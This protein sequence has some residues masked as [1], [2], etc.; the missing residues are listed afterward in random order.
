MRVL[1]LFSGTGSVGK[2]CNEVGF[3]CISLDKDMKADW[4]TDILEWD[5]TVYPPGHFDFIWASPPCDTFSQLAYSWIGRTLKDGTVV[6]RESIIKKQEELGVPLVKRTLEILDYFQ[7][8]FYCIENPSQSRIKDYISFPSFIVDYC[9]YVDWGYKKRTRLFTNL[10]T[11]EP[12][13]CDPLTCKSMDTLFQHDTLIGAK[14]KH[15]K[16]AMGSSGKGLPKWTSKLDRYRI[17][18]ELIRDIFC[19]AIYESKKWSFPV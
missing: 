10:K 18:P 13:V 6:T 1:E 16:V 11:F 4:E 12:K 7:P 14:R 15:K 8:E 2:I 3:E 5:Y 9:A 19:C 17:P